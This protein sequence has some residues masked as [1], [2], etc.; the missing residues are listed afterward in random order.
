MP[1]SKNKLLLYCNSF[2]KLIP[3]N[4]NFKD[5]INKLHRNHPIW[6]MIAL[7]YIN[8]DTGAITI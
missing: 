4:V 5:Y 3:P 1:K 2:I 8:Q 7:D 6:T